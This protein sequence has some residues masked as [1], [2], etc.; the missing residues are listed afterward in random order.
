MYTDA[1]AAAAVVA[2]QRQ[3]VHITCNSCPESCLVLSICLSCS[4]CPPLLPQCKL[5]SVCLSH[6]DCGSVATVGMSV[7]VHSC[8]CNGAFVCL[9]GCSSPV[10][11]NNN[12]N[13]HSVPALLAVEVADDVTS[14]R[15]VI[16]AT[17]T[18]TRSKCHVISSI[19]ATMLDSK[20]EP[21]RK[22][23][24]PPS[25]LILHSD[26]SD[27]CLLSNTTLNCSRRDAHDRG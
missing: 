7:S 15:D 10:N 21:L 8:V 25:T 9:C 3:G 16:A 11:G 19:S 17:P 4:T 22:S 20:L 27:Y 26:M 23:C 18:P 14:S 13:N 1:V 24:T 12:N 6:C 5:M 2:R